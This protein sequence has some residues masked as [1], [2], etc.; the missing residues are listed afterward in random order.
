MYSVP[1]PVGAKFTPLNP[2]RLFNWGGLV[3]RNHGGDLSARPMADLSAFGLV[4]RNCGGGSR[5]RGPVGGKHRTGVVKLTTDNGQPTIH[6]GQ[7][8]VKTDFEVGLAL[9]SYL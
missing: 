8:P 5:Y 3:R 4:R 9:L 1:L 2:E 6:N 7:Q